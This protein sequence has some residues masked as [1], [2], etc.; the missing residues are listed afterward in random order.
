MVVLVISIIYRKWVYLYK[1][2]SN[3]EDWEN[4]EIYLNKFVII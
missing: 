2:R 1:Y 3:R 4:I